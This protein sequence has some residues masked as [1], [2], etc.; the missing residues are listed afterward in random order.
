MLSFTTSWLA[1]AAFWM[2]L[3][4]GVFPA[5]A[6][7][8]DTIHLTWQDGR[9]GAYEIYY[10]RAVSGEAFVAP[11]NLSRSTGA[12][13]LPRILVDGSSVFIVWSDNQGGAY[14]VMMVR[15]D[16][17]GETFSDAIRLSDGDESTGPPRLAGQRGRVFVAWDQIGEVAAAVMLARVGEPPR[18]LSAGRGGFLPTVATRDDLVVV[19]WYT[20]TLVNQ[21]VY[22]VRSDDG[23]A[24][25]SAP[26][27][28]ST[29]QERAYAPSVAIDDNGVVYI[30]WHDRTRGFFDIFLTVSDDGARSFGEPQRLSRSDDGAIYPDLVELP[31]G[32]AAL[33]WLSAGAVLLAEVSSQ[34]ALA[35]EA[36]LLNVPD[37]AGPPRI[38]Q[39]A[40]GPIV[41]W[42]DIGPVS[43]EIYL[44]DGAPSKIA[45]MPPPALPVEFEA[46]HAGGAVYVLQPSSGSSSQAV[47]S[48]GEDGV[49]VSDTSFAERADKLREAIDSLG[50]GAVRYVI[51]T[52]FHS[53]HTD[54]N[55]AFAPARFISHENTL[56]DLAQGRSPAPDP[57]LP[58]SAMP[59]VTFDETLS[60]F[61]NGEE[62]RLIH[63]PDS[64]TEGDVAVFF[65]GSKVAHVGD[66]MLA[67]GA[68]PFTSN[69]DAL[70]NALTRL[71][72]LLP[73]D[74]VIVPGHGSL[75]TVDDLKAYRDIVVE[76]RDFV[77]SRVAAGQPHADIVAAI[78]EEWTSWNS[79]FITVEDWITEL[80][81]MLR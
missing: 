32:G 52:H 68:L 28:L 55:R 43:R 38:A 72:D 37:D 12:S 81:T 22:V 3:T 25:S 74:T 79:R 13:D 33:A 26:A 67:A 23:G 10:S 8:D 14:Q 73:E 40:T 7:A 18:D 51:N 39:T 53:D 49:L 65:T 6:A 59:Q 24:S 48:H 54:G 9:E 36:R 80:Y 62:V 1:L 64:H 20:D 70:V 57:P 42:D 58:D 69:V 19:A 78:P 4:T 11:V 34:G 41:A 45:A 29:G 71:I 44:S 21:E 56:R 50:G 46:V 76:T 47:V 15:S 16:D 35:N 5:V 2:Q 31:E 27:Q 30:A 77:L 75:A 17:S 63:L 60:V 66:V 61:F